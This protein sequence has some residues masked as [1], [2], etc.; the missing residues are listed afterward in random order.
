[1]AK[2][3]PET[4]NTVEERCSIC[5]TDTPHRVQIELRTESH[6]LENA[7]FSR[8]P[9]RVATCADCGWT[10]SRRMSSA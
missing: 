3:P 6:K 8:E 4:L 9:Y 1:M 2:T 7:V 10:T 5:S